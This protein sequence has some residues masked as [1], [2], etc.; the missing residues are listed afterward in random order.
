MVEVK[1]YWWNEQAHG[2]ANFG[3]A[4]SP[5]L[6]KRFAGVDCQ[7][8]SIANADVV[9]AGSLL[10]HIPPLWDGTILGTG[11]L[12]GDSRLSLY[13]YTANILALR[14]PLSASG[15]KGDYAIGDPG[16][17]ADELVADDVD[18][19][20]FDLGIVPHWSDPALL[21]RPDWYNPKWRTAIILPSL[22][23]L[24]VVRKIGR[25]KKIVTS[26][27]HGAIVAD[28]W[29]IPR[30]IEY[31]PS[32]D[33]DGGSFKFHDYSKS[34]GAPMEFGKV[35]EASRF[36]VEDRKH[37]LYDAFKAYGAECR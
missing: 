34:I 16:L 15:I 31:T 23:P 12:F 33:R 4:L 28:A 18:R 6:L 25:C 21:G 22:D 20:E 1:A 5:F 14:G 29:G 8:A 17:L 32:M 26:S 13:T 7:W 24:E 36:L 30:R 19:R 3:D 9:S 35:I 2:V 11:K 27:L 37:E 10:E